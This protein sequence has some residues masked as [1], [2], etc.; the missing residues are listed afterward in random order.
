MSSQTKIIPTT[1]SNA[2]KPAKKKSSYEKLKKEK[3]RRELE[4]MRRSKE[5]RE[6]GDML[7]LD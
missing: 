3:Q 5:F 4:R 1:V 6:L 7:Y 2:T